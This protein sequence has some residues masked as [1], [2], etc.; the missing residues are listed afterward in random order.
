MSLTTPREPSA[1]RIVPKRKAAA[2]KEQAIQAAILET[3]RLAYPDVF[4]FSVP[5]GGMIMDPRVVSKLKWQ[6]LRPGVPD[7]VLCWSIPGDKFVSGRAHPET[8]FLEIKRPG[9]Y[10][11]DDQKEVHAILTAKGHRVAVCRSVDDLHSTLRDWGVPSR[12]AA[13]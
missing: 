8:G 11:S 7:L 2:P 12:L 3:L 4:V 10:L 6:G 13:A 5:N 9:N 1:A